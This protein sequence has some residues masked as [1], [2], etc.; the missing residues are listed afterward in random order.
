MRI[1][2]ERLVFCGTICKAARNMGIAIQIN[3]DAY[4]WMD[5]ATSTRIVSS[6]GTDKQNSLELACESLVEYLNRN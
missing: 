2:D 1:N 4:W 5:F 3:G 6:P